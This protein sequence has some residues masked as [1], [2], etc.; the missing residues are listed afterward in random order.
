MWFARV[1]LV[2]VSFLITAAAAELALRF[3]ASRAYPPLLTHVAEHSRQF[4][5]TLVPRNTARQLTEDFDT[6]FHTNAE[7]LRV[8]C[9]NEAGAPFRIGIYGDSFTFGTGVGDDE[10]FASRISQALPSAEVRNVGVGG[11]AVDQYYLRFADD[12]ASPARRPALAIFAIF[13]NNDLDD[14]LRDW[15][16]AYLVPAGTA[17]VGRKTKPVLVQDEGGLT[18]RF[19][20]AAQLPDILRG[21]AKARAYAGIRRLELLRRLYALR[22]AIPGLSPV[23]AQARAQFDE[24]DDDLP[25]QALPP[26]AWCLDQ[27]AATGVKSVFLLIPTRDLVDGLTLGGREV[28]NYEA[29]RALLK[30]R[31]ALVIDLRDYLSTSNGYYFTH[32]GHWTAQGHEVVARAVLTALREARVVPSS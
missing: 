10:T 19:P 7:G 26:L 14:I 13:P 27:I 5:W 22:T 15:I 12:V 18:F 8:T 25:E 1:A 17:K 21:D 16:S 3:L 20:E 6:V 24:V 32:D 4:G 28:R 9:C 30:Q 23:L 31:N 2:S 11:Y 29:V